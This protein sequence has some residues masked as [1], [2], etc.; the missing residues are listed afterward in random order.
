MLENNKG[1]KQETQMAQ[2]AKKTYRAH[3]FVSYISHSNII[4]YYKSQHSSLLYDAEVEENRTIPIDT[5]IGAHLTSH[6]VVEALKKREAARLATVELRQREEGQAK[7]KRAHREQRSDI[8]H[9]LEV[10][11]KREVWRNQLNLTRTERRL[12]RKMRAVQH[13]EVQPILQDISNELRIR[14]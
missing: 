3:L 6:A 8:H 11:S 5:I 12:C 9:L 13:G 14:L 7:V 2:Y 4:E 10:A 1:S